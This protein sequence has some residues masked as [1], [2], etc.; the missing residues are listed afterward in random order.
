[1]SKSRN[2]PPHLEPNAGL[3]QSAP[4]P[5]LR[6]DARTV[7]RRRARASRPGRRS[8][9]GSSSGPRAIGCAPRAARPTRGPRCST[10]SARR[11]PSRT[12]IPTARSPPRAGLSRG[13]S[14]WRAG[15]AHRGRRRAGPRRCSP[16]TSRSRASPGSRAAT[17]PTSPTRR[18]SAP[19]A[20]PPLAAL[21]RRR[22]G[23]HRRQALCATRG[24]EAPQEWLFL[25]PRPALVVADGPFADVALEAGIEVD[26]PRRARPL[27]ARRRPPPGPAVPRDP[28]ADRPAARR[29]PAPARGGAR[30][31]ARSRALRNGTRTAT[32]RRRRPTGADRAECACVRPAREE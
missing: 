28:D 1:M 5:T 15:R 24:P 23:G 30:R 31:R 19:T 22:R 2:R 9:A 21:G 20:A 3:Q 16:S 32:G 11:P 4:P 27:R 14:R 26:R 29:L 7:E 25:V 6:A 10:C 8:C 17:S 18:H 12:S 13:S